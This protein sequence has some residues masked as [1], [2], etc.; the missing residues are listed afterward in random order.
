VLANNGKPE[1]SCCHTVQPRWIFCLLRGPKMGFSP[2]RGQDVASINVEF[3]TRDWGKLTCSSNR[4]LTLYYTGHSRSILVP[5]SNW[6]RLSILPQYIPLTNQRA[7]NQRRHISCIVHR[8]ICAMHSN[9]HM[10]AGR[11]AT[12]FW[13]KFKDFQAP[14]PPFV[15]A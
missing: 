10:T 1:L 14:S 13:D 2:C 15:Q 4:H 11:V 9:A 6:I 12:L 7:T 8:N 3:C 5:H